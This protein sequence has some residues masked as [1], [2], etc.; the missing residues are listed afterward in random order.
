MPL[1]V[2][3]GSN[4]R[5][6]SILQVVFW[7]SPPAEHCAPCDHLPAAGTGCG[8][9][10]VADSPP[11]ANAACGWSAAR[12][13]PL[14]WRT[15][16]ALMIDV[17]D[18]HARLFLKFQTWQRQTS[19]WCKKPGAARRPLSGWGWSGAS[20][21]LQLVSWLRRDG[22][23]SGSTLSRLTPPVDDFPSVNSV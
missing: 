13:A 9:P 11:S 23:P 8:R 19:N 5:R 1:S 20:S 12:R 2:V 14:L 17:P 22:T 15:P 7:W 21:S 10:L 4:Q 16:A 18:L 6:P 3:S